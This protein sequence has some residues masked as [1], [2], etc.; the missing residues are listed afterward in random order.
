MFC[1]NDYDDPEWGKVLSQL[2]R[3]FEV[4]SLAFIENWIPAIRYIPPLR[5]LLTGGRVS[6]RGVNGCTP[7]IA[8]NQRY[9]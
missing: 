8:F 5:N 4:N 3:F 6:T 2:L 7:L 9:S 1:R